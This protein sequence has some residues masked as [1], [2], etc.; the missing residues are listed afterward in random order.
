M[1]AKNRDEHN[2]WR[3]ITVGFRVSPEENELLNRAVKLLDRT[4][5]VQGSC[6]IHRAL[7]DR[8]TETLEELKRIEAGSGVDPDLLEIIQTITQIVDNLYIK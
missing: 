3:N 6:K 1:S 4:V 8:L 5:V 7:Y 2:R